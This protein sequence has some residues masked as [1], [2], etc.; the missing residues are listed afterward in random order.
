[1]TTAFAS[2]RR[3]RRTAL[4]AALIA[5]FAVLTLLLGACSA[6]GG[7]D[8]AA[9]RGGMVDPAAPQE[10]SG[11]DAD[12]SVVIEGSMSIVVDDV[13]AA[14]GDAEG[15]V[16]GADG[17][18]DGR[19]EYSE[20][21]GES[22]VSVATLV[23]RV[24][25]TTLDGVLDDLRT[26]GKVETLTTNSIDVTDSVQD[27]AAR[28]ASLETTLTRLQGFQDQ[29]TTI[30][31]LLTIEG[32][33]SDR[34]SELEA[35]QAREAALAERIDLSTI[36]LTLRAFTAAPASASNF[37]EG[38]VIGWNGL[39]GFVAGFVVVLGMLLPWLILMGLVAALVVVIVRL[40]R[41]Y[42]ARH[43][44]PVPPAPAAHPQTF[45]G[46]PFGV[47]PYPAAHPPA[48]TWATPA[49]SGGQTQADGAADSR[50]SEEP[51][52]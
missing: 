41:R 34:R 45:V 28:I 3:S 22:G 17:R 24:P 26:L 11:P 42:R 19:D 52:A 21:D 4:L 20:S 5:A 29:A 12:R 8:S 51:R 46:A 38:L 40:A 1:M 49:P 23:L 47:E 30:E 36:T 50:P 2:T 14:V 43:P 48:T 18:I 31:D 25:A 27:T 37:W 33:I 13:D 44:K 32:Q 9:D 10:E 39:V 15:L 16:I 7:G 35:L 6:G